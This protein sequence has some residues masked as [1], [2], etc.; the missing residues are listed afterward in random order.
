MQ[1]GARLVRAAD[2]HEKLAPV[3][4]E[5]RPPWPSLTAHFSSVVSDVASPPAA[6]TWYSVALA[7]PDREHDRASVVPG[8]PGQSRPRQR[9]D[10]LNGAAGEDELP[11]LARR[12]NATDVLSGDQNGISAPSVPGSGRVSGESS[13]RI[14]S[15]V[16]PVGRET[17]RRRDAGRRATR[18]AGP[19][20]GKVRSSGS[21]EDEVGRGAA[22][23]ETCVRRWPRSTAASPE[24]TRA[25][26]GPGPPLARAAP[27]SALDRRPR[28]GPP[29]PRPRPSSRHHLLQLEPRRAD[30]G[31]PRARV[32]AQAAAESSRRTAG[33]SSPA[34]RRGRAPA[35]PPPRSR[36]SPCRRR[37]ASGRSASPT[38]ARRRTTRRPAC[39]PACRAPARATCRR[40]CRGSRRRSSPCARASATATA[41][42]TT[43]RRRAES[44][45]HALARPKSSTFTLPSGVSLTFAG[46]RSRW[47]MPL[48]WASSSASA[49]CSAISS[50]SS[51]GIA[52]RASRSLRSSP[53]TSSR[54][55]NGFPSASS[56]P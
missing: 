5:L 27:R 26:A 2:L 31:Q 33:A 51:T 52:P 46:F 24:R 47:T 49:I 38:A 54:A 36:R 18:P 44:P 1:A 30:V 34:A 40:P 14:H 23:R 4:Q 56:S 32:L 16:V 7:P 29:A 28:R 15:C 8:A 55:R 13:G 37:R 9:A 25:T 42:A 11:D 6:D 53:S 20:S 3:R 10:S 22:S 50:A 48:L 19:K 35:S 21:V 41:S 12:T 39:R 45:A 43:S 17:R